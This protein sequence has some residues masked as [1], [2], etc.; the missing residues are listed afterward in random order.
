[1]HVSVSAQR[2]VMQ[3]EL[4]DST[5]NELIKK[6]LGAVGSESFGQS[7]FVGRP[8]FIRTVTFHYIGLL[9]RENASWLVLEDASWIADSGRWADALSTGKLSEVEPYPDGEMEI[10]RDV[11]VDVSSWNFDLPRKQI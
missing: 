7:S 8:V 6:G 10:S 5:I 2:S 3:I 11:I 1:M 4:D 9:I